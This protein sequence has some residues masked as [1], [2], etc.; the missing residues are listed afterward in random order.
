MKGH[1]IFCGKS[2]KKK[3]GKEEPRLKVATLAGCESLCQRVKYSENERIK[4]L[5]RSGIDLIAKEAE[6]HKSCRV[7][8][9]RETDDQDRTTVP[10]SSSQSYHKRAF[11]SVLTFVQ[12]EVI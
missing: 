9:L 10:A 1:C 6:Y 5:I 2:R 7:Q 11:E 4:S 3:S 8:F 12:N